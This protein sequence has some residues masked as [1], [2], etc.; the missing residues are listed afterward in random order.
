MEIIF[1][2]VIVVAALSV[3]LLFSKYELKKLLDRECIPQSELLALYVEGYGEI[4]PKVFGRSLA[5]V[6][7]IFSVPVGKIRLD[8][9]IGKDI[10]RRFPL[11]LLDSAATE[12][13]YDY[14]ALKEK[15]AKISSYQSI[16]TVSDFVR[17]EALVDKILK[18]QGALTSQD[19]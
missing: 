17:F 9:V 3:D 15:E 14:V 16:L 2:M 13:F 11:S 12:E 10:G 19:V 18:A 7:R 5:R 1:V 6:S 4:T 8:D